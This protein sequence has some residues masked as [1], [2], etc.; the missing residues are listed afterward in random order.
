MS[1]TMDPPTIA[2]YADWN[3]LTMALI[4]SCTIDTRPA[5]PST[6]QRFTPSYIALVYATILSQWRTMAAA[7]ATA[8]TVRPTGPVRMAMT[9]LSPVTIAVP[10][11]VVARIDT[12]EESETR[13]GATAVPTAV[14]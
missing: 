12:S 8:A 2:R 10:I 6:S 9:A 14:T 7:T 13:S 11:P 5:R 1:G 3:A 4:L